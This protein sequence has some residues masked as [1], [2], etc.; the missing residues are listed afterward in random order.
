MFLERQIRSD[1]RDQPS[2]YRI[3]LQH[4]FSEIKQ[5]NEERLQEE[6]RK[7]RET[8]ERIKKQT[9]SEIDFLQSR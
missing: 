6:K 4:H 2:L 3:N 5:I 1:R 9:Q 8:V 7:Q